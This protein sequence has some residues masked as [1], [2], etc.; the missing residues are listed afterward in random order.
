MKIKAILFALALT[1]I[2]AFG[3]GQVTFQN[4]T[5]ST[6][7]DVNGSAM[8]AGGQTW[9]FQFLYGASSD[10]LNFSSQVYFNS[11]TTPGRIAGTTSAIVLSVPANVPAYFQL[12]AWNTAAGSYANSATAGRYESSIITV[13]P[14][15]SPLS[16]PLFGTTA[17]SSFQG[18]NIVTVPEPS[19]FA[20]GALGI[21]ALLMVRRRKA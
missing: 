7:I 20:L 2:S 4:T 21:G 18:F 1:A 19:T 5:T 17:G 3:Q 15:Q 16:T 10:N 11:D 12:R 13:T 14:G 6:R 9:S 8:A